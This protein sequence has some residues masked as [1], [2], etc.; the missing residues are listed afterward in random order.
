[1]KRKIYKTLVK[2]P[3]DE[4]ILG[5][6]NGIMHAVCYDDPCDVDDFNIAVV[7]DLTKR[8]DGCECGHLLRVETD[9]DS[10]EKFETIVSNILPDFCIFD[11]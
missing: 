1:M 9:Q 6:I 8:D 11:W 5:Y 4:C 10:Y 3:V 2:A 7:S